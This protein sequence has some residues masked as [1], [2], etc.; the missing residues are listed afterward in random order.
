MKKIVPLFTILCLFLAVNTAT[1]APKT[2]PI[3]EISGTVENV[4]VDTNNNYTTIEFKDGRIITFSGIYTGQV[5]CKNKKCTIKYQYTD[6]M[7][8]QG[9]Y[10]V[11]IDCCK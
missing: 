11:D 7:F 2:F 1:A 4:I 5:F 3:K 10:M 6:A 8:S 9:T